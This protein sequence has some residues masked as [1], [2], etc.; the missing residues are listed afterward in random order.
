[1]EDYE[2]D[3]GKNTRAYAHINQKP[4]SLVPRAEDSAP[5]MEGGVRKYEEVLTKDTFDTFHTDE[6]PRDPGPPAPKYIHRNTP[7]QPPWGVDG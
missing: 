5:V 4:T 2:K 7:R 3:G 1:M 6:T